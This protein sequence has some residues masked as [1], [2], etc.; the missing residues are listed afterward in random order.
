MNK[1][2]FPYDEIKPYINEGDILL[3][4]GQ[5][6][7]SKI[8][9]SMSRTPYSHVALA[10]WV[11]GRANTPKGILECVEFREGSALAGLWNQNAAGGGRSI[12][13]KQC[14]KQYPNQIDVYRPV[15]SFTSLVFNPETKTIEIEKKEFNG[16]AVT[17]IMRDMAGLPYGWR[18]IWWMTK[19]KL[20]LLR[21]NVDKESL[22]HD[23]LG[24]IIYPVCST[25]VAYCFNYYGYDLIHNR[26]DESTEPGDIAL[27]PRINYLFTLG[28]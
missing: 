24:E 22:T 11:N 26:S 12:S 10:S 7:V 5:G 16:R 20:L 13:L 23:K 19:H 14:V 2:I 28:V 1:I 6:I 4:R 15:P 8:I 3:F 18:R 9:S 21:F 27:S 17:D 25:S